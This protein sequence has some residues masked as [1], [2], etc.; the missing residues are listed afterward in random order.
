MRKTVTLLF[1]VAA[2]TGCRQSKMQR[3]QQEYP[4]VQEGATSGTTST[5]GGEVRPPVTTD[6]SADTSTAFTLPSVNG[7][8]SMTT[9]PSGSVAGT[10]PPQPYPVQPMPRPRTPPTTTYPPMTS[11]VP[12]PPPPRIELRPPPT[13]TTST[14][15]T[16]TAKTDT[17]STEEKQSDE[18]KPDVKR[19]NNPPPTDTS[20][21][22]PAPPPPPG[23]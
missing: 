5:I 21:P 4:V 17:T 18:K 12:P 10:L 22:P 16:D 8:G 15:T 3:T 23:C 7:P 20:A 2:L 6:T 1:V 14:D 13:E 9:A 19:K 11:A